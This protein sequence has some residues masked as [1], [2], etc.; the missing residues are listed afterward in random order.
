MPVFFY[1][2]LLS[3]LVVPLQEVC[4]CKYSGSFQLVHYV[5]DVRQGLP[6]WYHLDVELSVVAAG[7]HVPSAFGTMWKGYD[8]GLEAFRQSPC[9]GIIVWHMPVCPGPKV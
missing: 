4:F 8:H 7:L 9:R 2:L 3:D 1:L 5:G 6:V